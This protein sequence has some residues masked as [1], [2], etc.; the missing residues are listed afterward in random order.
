MLYK[1]DKEKLPGSQLFQV[2]IG[3]DAEADKIS[4]MVDD[5][6]E[7]ARGLPLANWRSATFTRRRTSWWA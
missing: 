7:N 1:N 6:V 4:Q 5:I 3:H 2:I